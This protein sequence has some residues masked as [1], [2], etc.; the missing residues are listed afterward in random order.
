MKTIPERGVIGAL[1]L[2]EAAASELGQVMGLVRAA[3]QEKVGVSYIE[4]EAFFPDRVVACRDGRYFSYPYTID[5]DN[6]VQ[7]GDATEVV[8]QYVP[9][10][11]AEA[12]NAGDVFLEAVADS[13]GKVWDAVL[14]RA[15]QAHGMV[16]DVNNKPIGHAYY[17]DSVLREAA[18]LFDGARIFAKADDVHLKGGGK[19]VR[20]LAGWISAPRFVEGQA[21]DT[22]LI[23]AQV[24]LTA[25]P[26]RE[27]IT[28]AWK[29]GKHD[30]V[31]LSIDALGRTFREAKRVVAKAITKVNS[32]DLIVDAG[33]GGALVRLVEAATEESSDMTLRERMLEKIK[34]FKS[35]WAKIA[36]PAKITDE[37]L[38]AR[39]AEALVEENKP[40]AATQPA[41]V[42]AEQLAEVVRMTEA[43]SY[44]RATIA[45]SSLPQRAKEKVAAG[46]AG[47]DKYTEKDVD[48]AIKA[49]GD[50]VATFR[51]SGKVR[52]PF[53]D[54]AVEDR[55]Q[56]LA[57]MLDAFF[58]PKHKNHADV[59][60]FK[61]CY[62]EITGDRRIT[63]QLRECD[64]S[65]LSESIGVMREA[66]DSTSLPN[67]L[68]DAI[69][70]RAV[71]AYRA[72]VDFQGW[73]QITGNPVP[74]S[75][76][77]TQ[78]RVRWGG[79]GD[80]PSI[81]EGDPYTALTSPTDEEATYKAG[82][83]GGTEQITREMM[84]NDDVGVIRRIPVN[85][86]RSAQ[87][88]LSK[89]VFDFIR[90]NPTIYDSVAFFHA[91]HG[92]LGSTA[93]SAAEY[94][95]VRVAMAKQTEKD[96]GD[97]L[98]IYPNV[99][100]YPLDLQES[101]WNAFQRGTN[102]DKTFVQTLAPVMVPVWYW[103]DATDWAALANPEDLQTIEIG[104]VDGQE[105]PALFIQDMPNVGSMFSNDA[106]TWKIRHEYGGAVVDYRG[107]FKEVVAG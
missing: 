44:M 105:E 82:K 98:G 106:I 85:I 28:D 100:T 69:T 96:S 59:Q 94:G 3:V 73:R 32:V 86:G 21:P 15:G 83:K 79:Y 77:R 87:R 71:Q 6:K 107:A 56:K 23:K 103:T 40:A 43:R 102:L 90:T 99:I 47:R 62:I 68:G 48:D 42:T 63:G 84:K 95:V 11:I 97:R 38:E 101:V 36:D 51:E 60:S 55:S 52:L 12:V 31:S 61:E 24:N 2:R 81:G 17:P 14:I 89:F 16:F 76:F 93:F 80:L 27:T 5:T 53:D 22:G 49:E 35:I 45:A 4:I 33:A 78:H 54:I 104:F 29:R 19:D 7:L 25:G 41:G 92:N 39:Y 18:P 57:V 10:R 50:Y 70:R 37:D 30:L 65:R 75:D 46:F 34:A 88:T 26:L 58:D 72:A 66:L 67:V 1:A 64:L 8:E 13:D 74:L 91:S 20:S 9:V